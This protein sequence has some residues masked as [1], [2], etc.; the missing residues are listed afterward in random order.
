MQNSTMQGLYL[1]TNG[2]I[3]EKMVQCEVFTSKGDLKMVQCKEKILIHVS[4]PCIVPSMICIV[5]CAYLYNGAM[6]GIYSK[7]MI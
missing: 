6:Q 5:P 3:D 7:K 4:I 1:F 2:S